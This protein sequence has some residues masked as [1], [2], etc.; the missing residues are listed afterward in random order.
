MEPIIVL[1]WNLGKVI[2]TP[3]ATKFENS[4]GTK[5]P[6]VDCKISGHIV[7]IVSERW[8]EGTFRTRRALRSRRSSGTT[9]KNGFLPQFSSCP[10]IS[11][12]RGFH[13]LCSDYYFCICKETLWRAL[14]TNEPHKG[15]FTL[16]LIQHSSLKG[17]TRCCWFLLCRFQVR[18]FLFSFFLLFLVD[19]VVTTKKTGTNTERLRRRSE[20]MWF[21]HQTQ[22]VLFN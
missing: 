21:C 8:F 5:W 13:G 12:T 14:E 17:H 19:V 4:N 16:L 15:S 11:N 3:N 22:Q 9:M 1:H 18:S 7:V 6:R 20:Q 10:V 2:A